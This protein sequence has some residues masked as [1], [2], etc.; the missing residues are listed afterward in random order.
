MAFIFFMFTLTMYTP[1][2]EI[3]A[4]IGLNSSKYLLSSDINS[5]THEQRTGVGLGLGWAFPLNQRMK[6]EIEAQY[7]LKGAKTALAY[8]PGQTIQG[9]YRNS[10]LGIP[11]LFR[12]QLKE[13]RTPYVAIGP[14]LV[15]L[16]SH[17]LKIPA[18]G[19]SINLIDH[20]KKFVLAMNAKLGY[21]LPF[22]RW[23]LFAELRYER[24]LSNFLADVE[25]TV[26]SESL[27]LLIGGVYFL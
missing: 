16:L 7:S 25:A 20:T 26:K 8:A 13:K 2:R 24:W 6:L 3:R 9:I 18:T 11:F 14:E 10:S 21:E 17:H 5:L 12:Y 15:F 1:A 23:G 27:C 22:E 19:E 4:M